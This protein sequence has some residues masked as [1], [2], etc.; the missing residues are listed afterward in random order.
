MW[1]SPE[2]VVIC[3]YLLAN[4]RYIVL[5][6]KKKLIKKERPFFL[7]KKMKKCSRLV[8]GIVSIWDTD[9]WI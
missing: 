2:A 4:Y 9:I 8:V 5:L 3:I 7:K 6:T 1:Q